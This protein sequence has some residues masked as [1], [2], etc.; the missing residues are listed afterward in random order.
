MAV[1]RVATASVNPAC[2]SEM[3]S[4][5]P[6]TRI[7][8]CWSE[9]FA[10]LNENSVLLFLNT[11]VSLV[12]RYFLESSAM[13]LPENAI[14]CPR[15]SMTGN[16]TRSRKKSTTLPFWV[17]EQSPA[18]TISSFVN[19]FS[20][21]CFLRE[22]QVS[23]AYPMP[24]FAIVLSSRPLSL[25]YILA[26]FPCSVLSCE[27][28]NLAA[29]LFASRMR[30]LRCAADWSVPS[31]RVIPALSARSLTASIYS[32]FSYFITKEMTSPPSWHPKQ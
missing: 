19:P 32:R 2:H 1:P 26:F 8:L 31:G 23:G 7:N 13:V 27:K 17:L 24:Y 4:I 14:I 30:F 10:K 16:I 21:R 28:K 18:S 29:V 22:S 12:L 3:T 15:R 11:D 20:L 25:R 6:S 9:F 5:C